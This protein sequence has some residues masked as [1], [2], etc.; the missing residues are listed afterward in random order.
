MQYFHM[1]PNPN[2]LTIT[3]IAHI[4]HEHEDLKLLV[5]PWATCGNLQQCLTCTVVTKSLR[6]DL[7]AQIAQ[8][9]NHLHQLN[10]PMIHQNLK[11]ENVLMFVEDEHLVAKVADFGIMASG[12]D[13]IK[14]ISGGDDSKSVA[15]GNG[16]PDSPGSVYTAKTSTTQKTSTRRRGR[17]AKRSVKNDS[18]ANSPAAALFGSQGNFWAAPEQRPEDQG[19]RVGKITTKSDVFSLGLLA[20]Y[21][22]G[23]QETNPTF[24]E[25]MHALKYHGVGITKRVREYLEEYGLKKSKKVNTL[26]KTLALAI[27]RYT[28]SRP[29]M[30]RFLEVVKDAA[31][32]KR[33][34]FKFELNAPALASPEMNKDSRK[35]R[36]KKL[37][38]SEKQIRY[39]QFLDSI[40]N[41]KPSSIAYKFYTKDAEKGDAQA[42]YNLANCYAKGIGM[43]KNE[44]LAVKWYTANAVQGN[45]EAQ[46]NLALCYERGAGVE[47]DADMAFKWFAKSAEQ[48]YTL[49]QFNLGICYAKGIGT[50]ANMEKAAACYRNAAEKG[51]YEAMNNLGMCYEHGWG[52]E[53][54]QK[55]AFRLFLTSADQGQLPMAQF[56]LALCHQN[57]IG[58]E[59]DMQTAIMWYTRSAEAG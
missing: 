54:D 41:N 35:T 39:S 1:D 9:V 27:S 37:K 59:E 16:R 8:G 24:A 58:V 40:M 38:D 5:T 10:P 48:K 21:I 18:K 19:G 4:L 23:K 3:D 46:N 50:E 32:G 31:G 26:A 36:Q 17:R 14:L 56:N 55:Q 29:T 53:Q 28:T 52:V 20:L 7:C 6:V 51:S 22:L 44:K 2:V 33:G 49:G 34:R 25:S 57:G 47:K 42:Q 43:E 11:P 12:S 45:A 30:K 13:G 15:A